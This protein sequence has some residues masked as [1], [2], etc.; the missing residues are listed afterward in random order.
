M[1]CKPVQLAYTF[2]LNPS[3]SIKP[4]AH[5]L[6]GQVSAASIRLYGHLFKIQDLLARLG[7]LQ[8]ADECRLDRTDQVQPG[9]LTYFLPVARLTDEQGGASFQGLFLQELWREM[10][11]EVE[12]EYETPRCF[13]RVGMGRISEARHATGNNASEFILSD[14]AWAALKHLSDTRSAD[15]MHLIDIV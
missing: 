2:I 12:V 6:F 4:V 10:V 15:G 9:Q 1:T 13:H 14:D 5:D 3:P 11:D 7:Q 8:S